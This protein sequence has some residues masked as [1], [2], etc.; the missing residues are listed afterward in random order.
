VVSE[1]LA[2]AIWGGAD[3]ALGKH[4]RVV[5]NEP[6]REIVAWSATCIRQA[7]I[8]RPR[9]G[10]CAAEPSLTY[11]I[12]RNASFRRAQRA[13]SA[14]LA[15]LED[16]QR[17]VSAW[18]AT[19]ARASGHEWK[20]P[21]RQNLA[22]AVAHARAA[23]HTAR[24]RSARPARIY[25]VISHRLAQRT[26]EIACALRSGGR[27]QIQRMRWRVL[28]LVAV[29]VALGP[30]RRGGAHAVHDAMLFG[31]P[32]WTRRLRGRYGGLVGAALLAGYLPR[33]A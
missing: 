31:V 1:K 19:C 12:G 28:L 25:A 5:P 29:G 27:R 23:H 7:S 21:Y 20:T 15:S 30:R 10:L 18:T 32:R 22:R 11:W 14:P 6:W 3:A 9:N 33:A 26:R 24:W 16:V 17:A 2:R 4:V 13:P 8:G